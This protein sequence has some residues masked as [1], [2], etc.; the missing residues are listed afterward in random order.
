M[1]QSFLE[2]NIWRVTKSLCCN[3]QVPIPQ[4]FFLVEKLAFFTEENKIQSAYLKQHLNSVCIAIRIWNAILFLLDSFEGTD[5]QASIQLQTCNSQLCFINELSLCPLLITQSYISL[6]TYMHC[7]WQVDTSVPWL[8]FFS[9]HFS[10]SWENIL[11]F[12][13]EPRP[14]VFVGWLYPKA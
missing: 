11:S 9:W 3:L 14:I 7:L 12:F 1:K 10:F 5:D 2:A 6:S 13:S 8:P 4:A